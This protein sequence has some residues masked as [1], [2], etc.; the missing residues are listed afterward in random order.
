MAEAERRPFTGAP[1]K[2]TRRSISIAPYSRGPGW[3]A[4]SSAT[5]R[6][7]KKA[8]EERQHS[9]A[10][11]RDARRVPPARGSDLRGAVDRHSQGRRHRARTQSGLHR[12]VYNLLGSCAPGRCRRNGG[13]PQQ[14][15]CDVTA[16]ESSEHGVDHRRPDR[17]MF[18]GAV[19]ACHPKPVRRRLAERVGFEPFFGLSWPSADEDRARRSVR[20]ISATSVSTKHRI[21]ARASRPWPTRS[22]LDHHPGP[23]RPDGATTRRDGSGC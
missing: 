5:P 14:K 22:P 15:D 16:N 10:S 7:V 17:S 20:P 2:R 23:G 21:C 13:A 6:P 18:G 12:L 8:P 1:E 9:A 19:L 11:W 4:G 3:D